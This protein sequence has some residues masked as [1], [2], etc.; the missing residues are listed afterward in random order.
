MFWNDRTTTTHPARLDELEIDWERAMYP[1][2]E[3]GGVSGEDPME[4]DAQEQP[5]EG[6]GEG[7]GEGPNSRDAIIGFLSTASWH[8]DA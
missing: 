2:A 8:R 7:E 3:V 5:G 1:N 6:E 4:E